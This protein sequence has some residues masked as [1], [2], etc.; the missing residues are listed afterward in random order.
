[1]AM[2]RLKGLQERFKCLFPGDTPLI[3]P[4]CDNGKKP[5]YAHKAVGSYTYETALR[6]LK[7][8]RKVGAVVLVPS[9]VVVIDVDDDELA[10]YLMRCDP[11][12]GETATTKTRHGYHF[13]FRSTAESRAHGVKDGAR[14]LKM[15]DG[16]S[17]P[18]DVKTLCA[19][20]TR[21][22]VSIPPSP[23]KEWI[24]S[25]LECDMLPLPD[26]FLE[27]YK[28]CR[29]ATKGN[30]SKVKQSST[31]ENR[32]SSFVVQREARE[33][34][35]MLPRSFKDVY[36]DWIRVMMVLHNT[37]ASE[38]M[39]QVA[40][41]F[42]RDS[43]KWQDG[44]EAYIR[45]KWNSFGDAT[46][47]SPGD[48]SKLRM[49]TLHHW[50]RT[51]DPAKYKEVVGR[52][53]LYEIRYMTGE[54]NDVARIAARLLR[55]RFICACPVSKTWYRYDGPMWVE[56]KKQ[57]LL[58]HDLSTTVVDV[59]LAALETIRATEQQ[60]QQVVDG[61]QDCDSD[62]EVMESE[63]DCGMSS[64]SRSSHRRMSEMT[65]MEALTHT[66]VS[67]S[68]RLK[69]RQFKDDVV[70]EMMEY[71]LDTKFE[72]KLDSYPNLLGFSN[73][74]FDLDRGVFREASPADHMSKSV[75]YPYPSDTTSKSW[76]ACMGEVKDYWEKLHPEEDRRDYTVRMFARQL[77][78]DSGNELL[79]IHAGH[80][81]S[82]SNGKTSFF[83]GVLTDVLG[84]YIH[85][86]PISVLTAT[87]RDEANKPQPEFRYWRGVRIL[88]ATEP[89]HDEKINT[90]IMKDLTG[91]EAINYRLLYSNDVRSFK[92][93]A[94]Q[95][96][97][98]NDLPK[99]DGTDDGV[100]RRIRKVDYMAQFVDPELADPSKYMFAC[101]DTIFQKLKADVQLRQAFMLHFLSNFEKAWRFRMPESIRKE[102]ECYLK[103]NDG[104]RQFAEQC[105]EACPTPNVESSEYYFTLKRA[106]E[107]FRRH[108]S[109]NG[110]I[111][112]LKTDLEKVLNTKCHAQKRFGS[113]NES[114]VFVGYK[115]VERD[116]EDCMI[117]SDHDVENRTSAAAS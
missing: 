11:A 100:R 17:Y 9:S 80:M 102:S 107:M 44:S 81:G 104:V 76:H 85:K 75:G 2:E 31:F 95:H 113:K 37:D 116:D 15:S 4:A 105:I 39:L 51:H 63:S 60:E 32:M 1:M 3:M 70:I 26:A 33:L 109:F 72:D 111:Q 114:S 12:F 47:M 42:S 87:S 106:K 115:L 55:H 73:G 30:A 78:G 5:R 99:L 61:S 45:E 82:A 101:D 57:V 19:T 62:S 54:H 49:G 67:V 14:Q 112:T 24:R 68:K 16:S 66:I 36:G 23:G 93:M 8:C 10:E 28:A 77:Y 52:S 34:L 13:W 97:M 103:E 25:P 83:G 98:T 21:G 40:M 58:K 22:V 46:S 43:E 50:A 89:N 20:G 69:K 110:R 56:D 64:V 59:L 71:L 117:A 108:E 41:D 90:G 35:S 53:L 48:G 79:H 88:Y 91:G 92:P 86:F 38:A 6:K 7:E 96:V 94:K 74:V 84:D 18:I 65:E 27:F 29:D